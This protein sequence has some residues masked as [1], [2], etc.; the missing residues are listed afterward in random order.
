MGLKVYEFFL[1]FSPVIKIELISKQTYSRK[2]IRRLFCVALSFFVGT[3][4]L[5]AGEHKGSTV[6]FTLPACIIVDN[7][8][9][10]AVLN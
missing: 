9:A 5:L 7:G 8:F 3:G 1:V 2:L 4:S 10:I 6:P